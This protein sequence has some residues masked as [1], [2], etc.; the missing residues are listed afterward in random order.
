M[1]RFNEIAYS[2][3]LKSRDFQLDKLARR[4]VLTTKTHVRTRLTHAVNAYKNWPDINLRIAAVESFAWNVAEH[5]FVGGPLSA[6]LELSFTLQDYRDGNGSEDYLVCDGLT[7][8]RGSADQTFIRGERL[9]DY[10][11]QRF[12]ENQQKWLG[13]TIRDLRHEFEVEKL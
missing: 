11:G 1:L 8:L 13:K 7:W 4:T 3:E 5:D 6:L 9:T 2:A 12:S 10:D